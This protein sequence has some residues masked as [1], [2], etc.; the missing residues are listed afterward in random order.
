MK[1][2]ANDPISLGEVTEFKYGTGNIKINKI[3]LTKREYF[4]AMAMAKMA[5]VNFNDAHPVEVAE[6]SIRFADALIIELNR[7]QNEKD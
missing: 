6:K 5:E 2:K 1:T 7:G 3:G 4:A